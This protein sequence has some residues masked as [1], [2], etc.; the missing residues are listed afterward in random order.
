MPY[1]V[2]LTLK[3]WLRIPPDASKTRA[4]VQGLAILLGLNL[5]WVVVFYLMTRVFWHL[6]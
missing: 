4:N 5:F 6:P 3:K 1:Y 2:N